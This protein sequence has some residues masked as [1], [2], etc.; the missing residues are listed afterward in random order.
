MKPS[1]TG[2]ILPIQ[3]LRGIA[4][5]MVAWHH[6]INQ[7][8]GLEGHFPLRF[9]TSGVDLFFVISGF[10]MVMTTDGKRVTPRAFIARRLIRVVPL[11]WVLTL[12]LVAVILVAPSIFRTTVLTP[13]S[14]VQSLLFIPH[15][16]P[17][18]AGMI[19][20]VL[21]PGWTLN[22]EMFF[23]A[24]FAASLA[25][26]YRLAAL[27]SS[28]AVLVVAGYVF[29]PFANPIARTYTDPILL[30]FVAGAVIGH[31][32]IAGRLNLPIPVSLIGALI[33]TVLLVLRDA[34][35]LAN[36]TQLL[37][38]VLVVIGCLNISR[39][40]W[41]NDVLR[42]L[43]DAS[44]SIYLTHIFTLGAW[45]WAWAKAHLDASSLP[46]ATLF[47]VGA[48]V[49]C[50]IVGWFTFLWLETP[51]LNRMNA[52]LRKRLAST[53]PTPAGHTP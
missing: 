24:V 33:G 39:L 51:L 27:V 29:G 22:F 15:L 35:P 19:W 53:E 12:A 4:A 10:I 31:L 34:P 52:R 32:W 41:Q 36:F 1:P 7:I 49:L 5:L 26:R 23:Y 17:S 20:P 21:V 13:A 9:G 30:E 43:G 8:A 48:L 14:L 45:R 25:F 18:H 40:N 46:M 28:L 47:M 38:A 50:A 44:Y 42:A 6:G 2:V 3:Y 11:Y 37:G 16:S